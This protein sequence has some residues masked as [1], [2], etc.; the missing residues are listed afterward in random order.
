MAKTKD[1]AQ[2]T[3]SNLQDALVQLNFILQR[4]NDRLDALEGIRGEFDTDAGAT[5]AGHAKVYDDNDNLIHS[6]E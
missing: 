6:F 2:I 4:F 1:V 3:A 5:I